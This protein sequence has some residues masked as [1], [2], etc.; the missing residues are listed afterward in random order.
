MTGPSPFGTLPDGRAVELISLRAGAFEASVLTWGATV[1]SLKFHGE[2]VVVGGDRLDDYLGGLLYAGAVVGRFANRIGGA[3]FHL[4]GNS[5]TTDANF[6]G[7]HTLHGGSAGTGERL[8]SIVS[9]ASDRVCLGL[10]LADGDMGFPG[11]LRV[12]CTYSIAAEG[13][14]SV[15][16]EA[17]STQ[18]TPCSFAHHGYFCLDKS[19]DITG[20]RLSV[21]ADHYLPVDTDLIPTGEIAD[22]SGTVFDFREGRLIG[23]GGYDHNLCLSDGQMDLRPVARLASPVSGLVMD[24]AT[25]EPGLQVYDGAHLG[26]VVGYGGRALNPHAGLALETQS[27]P[28]APNRSDFPDCILRPGQSYRSETHYAF[29]RG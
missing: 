2:R 9:V 11:E 19:G 4:D 8:W 12:E 15:L 29:H 14:L 24:V 21:A 1:Q 28:D 5:Y 25:T 6:R 7:G 13:S 20:H 18:A 26:G 10:V 22:V 17:V 16:I 3:S 23:T 27:W